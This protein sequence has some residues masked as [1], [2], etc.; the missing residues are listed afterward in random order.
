MAALSL[1]RGCPA[2]VAVA[3]GCISFTHFGCRSEATSDAAPPGEQLIAPEAPPPSPPRL[4]PEPSVPE[5]QRPI[6]LP[7][8]APDAPQWRGPG[9]APAATRLA[10]A[11]QWTRRLEEPLPRVSSFDAIGDDAQ[12]RVCRYHFFTYDA[13]FWENTAAAEVFYGPDK[14]PGSKWRVRRSWTITLRGGP[15]RISIS[16]YWAWALIRIAPTEW[17]DATLEERLEW[18]RWA[19]PRILDLRGADQAGRMFALELAYRPLDARRAELT[20]ATWSSYPQMWH[21]EVSGEIDDRGVT[22]YYR[23]VAIGT[24]PQFGSL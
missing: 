5:D 19:L 15:V 6:A 12:D 11:K 8:A 21:E 17:L 10:W 20:T 3:L 24:G 1:A 16:E 2:V 14:E 22:L 4:P 18:S 13:D 9:P 23:R 7:L